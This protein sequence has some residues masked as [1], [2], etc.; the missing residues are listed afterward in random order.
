MNRI[1]LKVLAVLWVV[2]VAPLFGVLPLF[3]LLPSTSKSVCHLEMALLW[4]VSELFGADPLPR[5]VMDAAP[6]IT[7]LQLGLMSITVFAV[8]AGAFFFCSTK[9]KDIRR[10]VQNLR[11]LDD[12]LTV[13]TQFAPLVIRDNR[14]GETEQFGHLRLCDAS[15]SLR[16][17]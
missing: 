3:C 15:L 5:G 17:L 11:Q 6:P 8:S 1:L 13:Q 7:P 2:I 9:G 12:Q 16:Q 10:A 4:D 14:L